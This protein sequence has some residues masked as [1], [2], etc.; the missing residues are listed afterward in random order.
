M[1]TN[2]NISEN[3]IAQPATFEDLEKKVIDWAREK[4]IL[5]KATRMKQ[6]LKTLEEVNELL[7]AIE[8]NDRPEIIDALGDVLVTIIIQAKMNNL[9][10]TSCLESAYNVIAKRKGQMI[11]GQ[12]VKNEK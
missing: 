1:N 10:L 12:F 5:Q 6:G 3:P 11:K 9:S 4:G 8:D 7:S 2:N